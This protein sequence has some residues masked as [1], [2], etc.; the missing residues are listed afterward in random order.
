MS[1][2]TQAATTSSVMHAWIEEDE[3]LPGKAVRVLCYSRTQPAGR[4]SVSVATWDALT[5]YMAAQGAQMV[6]AR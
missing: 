1:A 5:E 6:V 2:T 3:I 4:P